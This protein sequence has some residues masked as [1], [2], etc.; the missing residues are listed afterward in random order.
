VILITGS[1]ELHSNNNDWLS[2]D[3][4]FPE[5]VNLISG[6]IC[7]IKNKDV[8]AVFYDYHWTEE[9]YRELFD[10]AGLKVVQTHKPLGNLRD[11]YIWK[12]EL[13]VSPHLI[14]ILRKD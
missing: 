7:K 11:P 1:E 9:D 12:D 5:N 13:N 3:V 10:I 14:Y 4:N 2:Y 6:S 8:G